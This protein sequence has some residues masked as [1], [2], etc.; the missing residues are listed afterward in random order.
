MYLL[1]MAP[2]AFERL[3]GQLPHGSEAIVGSTRNTLPFGMTDLGLISAA[4][5]G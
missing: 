4:P 1:A 2:D 5:I 3:A